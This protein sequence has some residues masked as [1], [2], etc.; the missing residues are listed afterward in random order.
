MIVVRFLL[1]P[2]IVGALVTPSSAQRHETGLTLGRVFSSEQS[3]P[4]GALDLKSGTALQA[5]YGVRIARSA[6]AA[7]FGEVHLLS[8][9]LRDVATNQTES[10]ATSRRSTSLP[11]C[12]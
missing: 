5:N 1:L 10:P 2:W 6:A 12:G 11:A 8:S 4:I 7:L 3:I 9:P